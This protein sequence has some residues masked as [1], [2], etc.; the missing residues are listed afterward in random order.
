MCIELEVEADR[1]PSSNA[2]SSLSTIPEPNNVHLP[3]SKL[4]IH[5]V[6]MD[7]TMHIDEQF[8]MLNVTFGNQVLK[9]GLKYCQ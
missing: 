8:F 2:Y 9:L 7:R 6:H 3:S 4:H 5:I 1:P